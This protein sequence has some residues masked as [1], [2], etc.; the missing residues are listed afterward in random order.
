MNLPEVRHSLAAPCSDIVPGGFDYRRTVLAL[1]G[2]IGRKR[3]ICD[4]I[5]P[6][7]LDSDVADISPQFDFVQLF[8]NKQV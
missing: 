3:K 7:G 2:E 1:V 6:D 4:F 8:H 5:L